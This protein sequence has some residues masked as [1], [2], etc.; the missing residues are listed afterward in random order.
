LRREISAPPVAWRKAM[1]D[2]KIYDVPAEWKQR[3]YI[4]EA[5]YNEIYQR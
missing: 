5:K 1:S 3:G 4:D 2:D